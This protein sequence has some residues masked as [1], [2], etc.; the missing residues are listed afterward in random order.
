MQLSSSPQLRNKI[1]SSMRKEWMSWPVKFA[2]IQ[3]Q[4]VRVELSNGRMKTLIRCNHCRSLFDRKDIQCNHIEPVGALRSTKRQDIEEYRMRMFCS[5]SNLEAL[6]KEC[7]QTHTK[8][9]RT[10]ECMTVVR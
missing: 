6:C 5:K 3:S 2:V 8:H 4:S 9:Q 7:H 1:T 10:T